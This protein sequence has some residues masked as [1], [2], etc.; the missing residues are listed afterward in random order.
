MYLGKCCTI[1]VL[2]ITTA[3]LLIAFIGVILLAFVGIPAIL[4]SEIHKVSTDK[5]LFTDFES[6]KWNA[7]NKVLD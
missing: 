6:K 2:C 4:K 3:A 5:I 7:G 1:K